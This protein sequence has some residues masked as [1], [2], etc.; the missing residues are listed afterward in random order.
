MKKILVSTL[1]GVSA[2]ASSFTPALAVKYNGASVYKATENSITTVYIDGTAGSK[3]AVDLGQVTKTTSKLPTA[4]G[5]VK[6]S[7]PKGNTSYTGLTVDE[8]AI[9][10]ASLPIQTLPT[11]LNGQF[12][13]TRTAN[14]K[15]A[16][17]QVII[18][19]KTPNTPVSITVPS[20]LLRSL[21]INGCGT[22]VL[23]AAKGTTLPA[24]FTINGTSYTLASL[25]DA[26]HGSVCKKA[27]DGTYSAYTPSSW[28]Q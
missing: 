13:E 9:D 25:P 1:V 12:T 8:V 18:V 23:K 2:V 17:G 14:F 3:V 5:D 24:T 11:C 19:G 20:D 4:C 22:G 16:K 21:A 15:T 26:G 6:I 10:Y 7:I 27:S 28:S